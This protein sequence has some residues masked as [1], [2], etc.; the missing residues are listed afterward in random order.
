MRLGGASE[1][2]ARLPNG[3]DTYLE[4]PVRDLYE[5]LPDGATIFGGKVD[6][7]Y[8]RG[9]MD[10]PT[11]KTLSGGEMQRIAVARTFMRSAS[12]EQKVGLLVFDEPSASLDPTAEQGMTFLMTSTYSRNADGLFAAVADLFSR[13][14]ELRGN[15]T[16]IFSTHRFGDLTRHADL[17]M[18]VLVLAPLMVCVILTNES[19][20]HVKDSTILERGTHEQLMKQEG[21][22]YA[23]LWHIQAKAFL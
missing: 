1:L 22:D 10:T 9:L 7:D 15:K 21:S 6:N 13:L 4:R 11:D 8:L 12:E 2:I 23:R 14:R 19:H 20:R 16:M 5:G 3:L 18:W 17:I